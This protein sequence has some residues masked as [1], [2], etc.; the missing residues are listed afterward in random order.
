MGLTLSRMRDVFVVGIGLHR[1]QRPGPTTYVEL[2]LTA[3]RSALAD[4]GILWQAVESAYIGTALLGMGSGGSMLRYLG[5]TGLA[6][7]HV[8][9]ASASGSTAFRQ[10]CIDVAS[11]T[12]DVAIAIGIDKAAPVSPGSSMTGIE[13]LTGSVMT[14]AAM[15][16]LVAQEYMHKHDVNA[17]QIAAV[18]V[19]NH[20]NAAQ[21]P[22]AHFQKKRTLEEVLQA[23]PIAGPLTRLQ[24]CP[25][26]EGAAVAIVGSEK[27]IQDLGMDLSRAIRVVSS[28][29]TSEIIPEAGQSAVTEQTRQC[30]A[31]A[32][33]EADMGPD[34]MDIIEVHDAF[35]I[36]ELMYTEALGL[37]E[38]GEGARLLASGATKIGGRC[39]VSPS[40][41]LLA[42]GHPF[43]PTGI[44]QIVEITRQLRGE[45]GPR[46]H[47][48]AHYGLAHMVGIG[49]VCLIHILQKPN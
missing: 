41:G 21:N 14:P 32:Y 8:E 4:A 6:I 48:D 44:G 33:K 37:C 34:Q 42:M 36:E 31:R 47:P 2:G 30:A 20:N 24:C 35:T 11:G 29:S 45:A 5:A 22:F 39:A 3:I 7:T 25:F 49:P 27:A 17:E 46:Q 10:A 1:Y 28:V 9:N 43:G 16:A 15:F 26:S 13:S 40:G 12:S 19:K 18:A 23:V 38:E